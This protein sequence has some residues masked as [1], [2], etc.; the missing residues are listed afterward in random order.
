MII[1]ES[2][3]RKLAEIYPDKVLKSC[4]TVLPVIF[5]TRHCGRWMK[6]YKVYDK[7]ANIED[8]EIRGEYNYMDV[9]VCMVCGFFFEHG[10]GMEV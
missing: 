9:F 10:P 6:K 2:V 5:G 8:R 1:Q 7:T 4:R 3:E